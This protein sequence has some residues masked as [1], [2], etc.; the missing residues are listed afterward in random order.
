MSSRVTVSTAI[1]L[2]S[3]LSD[4]DPV[5]AV[6][7]AFWEV[8]SSACRSVLDLLEDLLLVCVR[9]FLVSRLDEVGAGDGAA[10]FRPALRFDC[11][12]FD[13]SANWDC[14][15]QYSSKSSSA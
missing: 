15:A 9:C 11:D 5:G 14:F 10:R 7:D 8:S 4:D 1:T 6:D 2:S 12:D 3:Q 13:E